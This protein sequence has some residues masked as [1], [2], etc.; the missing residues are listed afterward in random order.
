MFNLIKECKN[1]KARRGQLT[2]GHFTIETP[3]FMPV[4]TRATVKSITPEELVDNGATMI[5]CN[6]YHMFL[7]PGHSIVKKLGGLH[8]FM[9][10]KRGILT[11]SGGFQIF[12]LSKLSKCSDEGVKF[13]SH[14]DGTRFMFRP[15]DS[16]EV[17]EALGSD[18]MM[19]L[20]ELVGSDSSR[21]T[22]ERAVDRTLKWALR[23]KQVW[24]GSTQLWGIVQ[25]GVHEDIR[26]RCAQELTRMDFPGYAIG[27]LAVGESAAEMYRV[28]DIVTEHL[29]SNKSRYLMGV[30]L[31][32]NLIECVHRGVDLF[33]CVL[34]TRNARNG[35]LFTSNGKLII[36]QA[37]YKED[38]LPIDPECQC[39]TCK[40]YSRAYLR[41]LFIANEILS[42][43]LNTI[44][45]LHF[46]LGLMKDIR[47]SIEDDRFPEF[48]I[49]FLRRYQNQQD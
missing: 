45:N 5:L 17:Q 11:D 36:K 1:T 16:I 46:Y 24:S 3:Q 20:D 31:P 9:N 25:G 8:K 21:D 44:H 43:R 37:R 49:E 32:E 27:G 30:G 19:V 15:E 23:C 13:A 4:G 6:T 12:S 14:L 7:R 2:T 28:T 18:V 22:I 26:V 33:D 41:H 29:P 47:S 35:W 48:R 40:N 39:Y 42:S 38:P 10:W 34:P